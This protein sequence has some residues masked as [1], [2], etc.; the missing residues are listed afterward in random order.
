MSASQKIDKLIE[1]TNI[2]RLRKKALEYGIVPQT[3][4]DWKAKVKTLNK[5]EAYSKAV[6][7]KPFTN[8]FKNIFD[9]ATA[10]DN[11]L[12]RNHNIHDREFSAS[13]HPSG[14]YVLNDIG[15]HSS[16]YKVNSINDAN[17]LHKHPSANRRDKTR[18]VDPFARPLDA[19]TPSPTDIKTAQT[20]ADKLKTPVVGHAVTFSGD[21]GGF[22]RYKAKPGGKEKIDFLKFSPYADQ[23]FNLNGELI[24]PRYY[25]LKAIPYND[26]YVPKKYPENLTREIVDIYKKRLQ[27]I[28]NKNSEIRYLKRAPAQQYSYLTNLPKD[29][30]T[31]KDMLKNPENY[32]NIY[33]QKGINLDNQIGDTHLP[34][35]EN[36]LL[37][38]GNYDEK[39]RKF[40]RVINLYKQLK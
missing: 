40:D 22:T 6:G 38:L 20:S 15:G 37:L 7:G 17:D 10:I 21:T 14:Q 1:E 28:R 39:N 18:N 30:Y 12:K 2:G 5:R 13:L 31:Y 4:T 26:N 35:K 19:S 36:P 27:K 32:R 8:K 16:V 29:S 3:G 25:N 9:D 23:K 34:N 11:A 33:S 24:N